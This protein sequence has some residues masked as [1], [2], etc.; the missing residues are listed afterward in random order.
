M[1]AFWLTVRLQHDAAP[2]VLGACE[3]PAAPHGVAALLHTSIARNSDRHVGAGST[4]HNP[5]RS[6]LE[7]P[8]SRVVEKLT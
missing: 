7:E 1:R 3:A 6:R 2:D 8:R 5:R 4:G